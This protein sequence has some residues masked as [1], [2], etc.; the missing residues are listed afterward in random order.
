MKTNLSQRIASVPSH[1]N[2]L[3]LKPQKTKR[4][5]PWWL[6]MWN[7]PMVA[8]PHVQFTELGALRRVQRRTNQ[9]QVLGTRGDPTLDGAVHGSRNATGPMMAH[10]MVCLQDAQK[11]FLW[12]E[13]PIWELICWR[14]GAK[15][16][17]IIVKSSH[18]GSH[19]RPMPLVRR[20]SP[21]TA[22]SAD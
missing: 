21:S 1:C 19:K 6:R 18:R 22:R 7:S 17:I 4:V 16:K 3:T 15:T 10:A 12:W 14:V 8:P 11:L 2:H 13:L 5:P 9:Q 20:I